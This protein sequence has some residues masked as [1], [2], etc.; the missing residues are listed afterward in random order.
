MTLKDFN[1][2]VKDEK[3]KASADI[4]IKLSIQRSDGTWYNEVVPVESYNVQ[5]DGA[6]QLSCCV[7]NPDVEED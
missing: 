3:I 5:R 6:F 1:S 4:K 2:I 7:W